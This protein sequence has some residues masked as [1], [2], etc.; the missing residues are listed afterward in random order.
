MSE[1][2]TVIFLSQSSKQPMP[3]YRQLIARAAKRAC[4]SFG[5]PHRIAG[6]ERIATQ[7]SC[8]EK[9]PLVFQNSLSAFSF[10]A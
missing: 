3:R 5:A 4:K 8:Y 6:D 2:G 10:S 9:Q 7:R 1:E